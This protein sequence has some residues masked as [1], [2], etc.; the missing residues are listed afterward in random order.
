MR[1]MKTSRRPLKNN[2]CFRPLMDWW[3]AALLVSFL[4][5]IIAAIPMVL[6]LGGVT[7]LHLG[8]ALVI[9]ATALYFIDIGFFMTYELGEQGLVVHRHVGSVTYSYRSMHSLKRGSVRHLFS[10]GKHKRYSLS[11][12]CLVIMLNQGAYTTISVS[13][14][15]Q[16]EFIDHILQK[17]DKERSSRATIARKRND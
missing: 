3:V 4:A 9:A 1:G 16:Q 5:I 14:M 17:I 2:M 10:F 11:A 12:N 15:L 13:P 7:A 8:A 6:W